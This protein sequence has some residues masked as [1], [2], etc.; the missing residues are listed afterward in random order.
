MS[1]SEVIIVAPEK[2]GVIA[3]EIY[4]HFAEQIGGVVYDGIFVGKDSSIP[5]INGFRKDVLE[6]FKA[7]NPPV[8]RWPG[9]CFA[10]T[11]HWKDGVGENRPVRPSWWTAM[12][13]RYENNAF[14]THEFLEF[15]EL[16]GAKPYIAI[17]ITSA[18]PM[19]AREWVDYCLSPKG[20][21]ELAKERE[22]NGR[23]E[24]FD[25]PYWGIGNENWGGGGKMTAEEY[26]NRYRVYAMTVANA[27]GKGK[28]VAGACCEHS[29]EWAKTFLANVDTV[30]GDKLP[31]DG[32]SLHHYCRGGEAV[33]FDEKDWDTLIYSAQRMEEFIK[34]HGAMLV[35]HG[36]EKVKLYID[37]WG[38]MHP[39][40]TEL[41]EEKHLYQQQSTMRDAVV[42]AYN[43]NLFNNYCDRV[44]MANIAQVSNCLHSLFLTHG[45]QFTVTPTYYVFD[46]YKNHQGGD[47]LRTLTEDNRLSVSASRKGNVLT[48][49]LANLSY[50]EDISVKLNFLG[51]TE[52]VV[53]AEKTMLAHEDMHAHNTFENP[54]AVLPK[55]EKLSDEKELLLPKAS[56]IAL[57]YLLEE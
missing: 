13:G 40:G 33:N 46:M 56:V 45:E 38:C 11:Y 6:K 51:L 28:L 35:A 10:E 22:K 19:E 17:N 3:P 48:V 1:V 44:A 24:P 5:N 18:T 30:Y 4:G 47:C 39:S 8:L 43:L 34:R 14:G 2:I 26:A 37:E 55:T 27:V 52:K 32:V 54:N 25:I 20:T 15:C 21:T 16:V 12:D 41:S 53:K 9:G 57:T 49:T 7:I 36:K 42:A 23:A 50:K 29:Y 31:L